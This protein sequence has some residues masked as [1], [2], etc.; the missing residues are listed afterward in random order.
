MSKPLLSR[1]RALRAAGSMVLCLWS[2]PL[3]STSCHAPAARRER[4]TRP[5]ALPAASSAARPAE[6]IAPISTDRPGFLFAPTVV[7]PGRLQVETGVPTLSIARDAGTEA[8]TWTLPVA[9]RYG[10]S[11]TLEL[12]AS[13]PTWTQT[14]TEVGASS[15]RDEGFGDVELGAKLALAPLVGG[16]L[17]LQGSL[18]LPTGAEG[19][20]ADEVGGSAYLL[21]G[22]EVSGSWLQTLLGLAHVPFAEAED[23]TSGA[24]AAL[25]SRPLGQG[26][27]AY[28]EATALPGFNHVPGQSYLGTALIWTPI[29]RVQLDLSADFGLDDDS[30][31]VLAAFG[32]S[33]FL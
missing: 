22:R 11:E 19:F 25:I 15:V 5:S 29:V 13:L 8:R 4:V 27:S 16:P 33:W 18:R 14:R 30:A 24:L 23:Q 17:A 2:M 28:V 7:P 21:H 3:T 10:S 1:P 31:D 12:R 32:I 6:E 20:T 9:L 26:W